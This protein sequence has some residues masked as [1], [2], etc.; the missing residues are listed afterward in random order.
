M[1]YVQPHCDSASLVYSSSQPPSPSIRIPSLNALRIY[2]I[3]PSLPAFLTLCLPNAS[4]TIPHSDPGPIS[5]LCRLSQYPR[6]R[7]LTPISFNTA[8]LA[9]HTRHRRVL[10]TPPYH[11]SLTSTVQPGSRLDNQFSRASPTCSTPILHSCA[12]A[13]I[14]RQ[15]HLGLITNARFDAAQYR[16][17]ATSSAHCYLFSK[18]ATIFT[19][20][21]PAER[22]LETLVVANPKPG[23]RHSMFRTNILYFP[24]KL[25]FL[26]RSPRLLWELYYASPEPRRTTP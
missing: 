26:P 2:N 20:E 19:S 11:K 8:C 16:L 17:P 1:S 12:H 13:Y 10:C 21:S 7:S 15:F 24:E 23:H 5:A 3:P 9:H 18:H 6:H 22:N 25:R 14:F 4:C